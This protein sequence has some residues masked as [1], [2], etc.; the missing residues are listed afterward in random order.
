MAIQSI[1]LQIKIICVIVGLMLLAAACTLKYFTV[2]GHVV[3][4]CIIELKTLPTI[5]LVFLCTVYILLLFPLF[6]FCIAS[7]PYAVPIPLSLSRVSITSH[8]LLA[9]FLS[10]STNWSPRHSL[11]SYWRKSRHMS[12]GR[13]V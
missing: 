13:Y 4:D 2:E 7:S 10:T 8:S 11:N 3:T 6:F 9:S 12:V 5:Y 1:C